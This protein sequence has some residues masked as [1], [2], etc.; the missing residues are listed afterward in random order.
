M[1]LIGGRN[2]HNKLVTIGGNKIWFFLKTS[3][4]L[5]IQSFF[6]SSKAWTNEDKT[7]KYIEEMNF[8]LTNKK[9]WDIVLQRPGEV[10][11]H[12]GAFLHAACTI[13]QK[14]SHPVCVSIG[15]Q[16]SSPTALLSYLVNA[17]QSEQGFQS[18]G[19]IKPATTVGDK[20]KWAIEVARN[21]GV[22]A[23]EVKDM[24]RKRNES[25]EKREA[26]NK[27]Q[28]KKK[29]SDGRFLKPTS[30]KPTSLKPTSQEDT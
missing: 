2:R 13:V 20:K 8:I 22:S 1:Y 26:T 24:K 16:V 11:E 19:K 17:P 3:K 30:L 25:K 5:T 4:K 29:G 12:C 23:K 27:G 6:E 14:R 18:Q 10:M 15:F 28:R 9:D 21:V 7:V